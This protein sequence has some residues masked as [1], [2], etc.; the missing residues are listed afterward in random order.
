M[1]V[2][3]LGNNGPYPAAGGACSSY[4]ISSKGTTILTDVGPGSL[5]N[6]FKFCD[7][8]TLD[9]IVLS[10]L[11]Y[12]HIS[13]LYALGYYLAINK[14]KINLLLP[15]YPRHIY[16]QFNEN[17]SFDVQVVCDCNLYHIKDITIT[18]CEMTHPIISYATKYRDSDSNFVYS[19]DTNYNNRLGAFAKDCDLLIVDG[20]NAKP[21]LYPEDCDILLYESNAKQF[22]VSHLNPSFDNENIFNQKLASIGDIYKLP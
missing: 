5:S 11:H 6:L 2:T 18:F 21:H 7:P 10:H 8:L 22:I 19:G 15:E 20:G 13:D 16:D 9:A 4:L 12:D 17:D 14:K 3:V 1:K